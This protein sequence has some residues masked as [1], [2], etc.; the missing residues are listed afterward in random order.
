[1]TYDDMPGSDLADI[2]NPNRDRPLEMSVFTHE[3]KIQICFNKLTSNI[4]LTKK[5]ANNLAVKL[6]KKLSKLNITKP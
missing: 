5:Q 3:D 2:P 4:Q 1:M 6:M